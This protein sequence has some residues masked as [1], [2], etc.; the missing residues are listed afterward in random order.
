GSPSPSLLVVLRRVPNRGQVAIAVDLRAA[1][2]YPQERLV[3]RPGDVLVLQE[4][5]GEA[6]ARYMTQ[7][8][9]NFNAAWNIFN[10]KSGIGVIDVAT[11]D[12]LPGRVGTFNVAP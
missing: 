9:F 11:P 6:F 8:F 7:T 3:I 4:K 2:R 12:R 10:S 5:P 1:L